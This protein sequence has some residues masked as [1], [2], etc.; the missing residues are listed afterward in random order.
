LHRARPAIA[1]TAVSPRRWCGIGGD[2]LCKQDGVWSVLGP[3]RNGRAR[4]SAVTGGHVRFRRTAGPCPYSSSSRDDARA[5]RIV[6]P[7]V[8]GA[9]TLADEGNTILRMITV[10][11]KTRR[12]GEH[13]FWVGG[14][15]WFSLGPYRRQP[16]RRL[17]LDD[18]PRPSVRRQ[19][20]CRRSRPGRQRCGRRPG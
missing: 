16:A 19:R 14:P 11:Y 2:Q 9:W 15:A 18:H 3:C 10:Q 13:V 8:S 6:V 5:I 4:A 17:S 7:T 20:R 12:N 1:V